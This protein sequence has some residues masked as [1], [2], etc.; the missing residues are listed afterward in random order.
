[1]LDLFSVAVCEL[2]FDCVTMIA[3][4]GVVLVIV[5]FSCLLAN[6]KTTNIV[7][8]A[9]RHQ[10]LVEVTQANRTVEFELLA[11]CFGSWV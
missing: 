1:M 9:R 4:D 6:A 8:A 11:N 5:C 2:E 3:F 10:N 7:V